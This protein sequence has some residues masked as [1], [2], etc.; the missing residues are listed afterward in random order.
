M[1][2]EIKF[3]LVLRMFLIH[4]LVIVAEH[5][6]YLIIHMLLRMHTKV[7]VV[8]L[9]IFFTGRGKVCFHP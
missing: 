4:L 8:V 3:I 5:V 6:I 1:K 9:I 7:K 2:A